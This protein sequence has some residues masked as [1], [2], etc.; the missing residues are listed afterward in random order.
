MDTAHGGGVRRLLA[1]DA[2]RLQRLDA[3]EQLGALRQVG[4][5]G[6]RQVRREHL[7]GFLCADPGSASPPSRE[8]TGGEETRAAFAG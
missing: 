2:R 5:T 3:V 8:Q 7:A 1:L 4:L 6:A